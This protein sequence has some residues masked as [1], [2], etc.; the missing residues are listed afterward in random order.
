M[1]KFQT[2]LETK[3]YSTLRDKTNTDPRFLVSGS[4]NMLIND[5]E[6][7]VTRK[8]YTLKGASSAV[9]NAI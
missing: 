7:V 1:K 5:E 2:V 4:Q 3:G 8:G 6:K 9:L